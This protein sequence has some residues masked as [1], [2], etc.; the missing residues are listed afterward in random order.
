MRELPVKPAAREFASFQSFIMCFPASPGFVWRWCVP[1]AM[2][3][4]D[5]SG[6]AVPGSG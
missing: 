1:L 6:K 4:I 3:K 2:K 5:N